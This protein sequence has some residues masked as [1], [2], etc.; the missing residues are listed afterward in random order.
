MKISLC[1]DSGLHQGGGGIHPPYFPQHKRYYAITDAIYAEHDWLTAVTASYK[2]A[3]H[4]ISEH[5]V[6]IYINILNF[7]KLWKDYVAKLY[8][9]KLFTKIF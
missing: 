2:F 4:K 6:E 8:M 1:Q 7:G 9:E 5:F 3:F